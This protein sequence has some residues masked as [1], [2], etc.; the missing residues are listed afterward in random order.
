M[1]INIWPSKLFT[2]FYEIFEF[3]NLKIMI[4]AVLIIQIF[5]N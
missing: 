1:Q 5:Q 2:V 4:N 3:L